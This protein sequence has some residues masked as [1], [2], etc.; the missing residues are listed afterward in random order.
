MLIHTVKAIR[1]R[2]AP[3][4]DLPQVKVKI[5]DDNSQITELLLAKCKLTM[6]IILEHGNTEQGVLQ[7]FQGRKTSEKEI[8]LYVATENSEGCFFVFPLPYLMKKKVGRKACTPDAEAKLI[9][10][11]Q[12]LYL[13]KRRPEPH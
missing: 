10:I 4:Q 6:L 7:T 2:E 9:L 8:F 13:F 1:T 3:S 11:T 12:K 5:I